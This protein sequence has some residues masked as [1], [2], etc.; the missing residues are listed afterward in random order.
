MAKEDL[1]LLTGRDV[2]LQSLEQRK[3]YGAMLEG[4]PTREKNQHL[5]E[6]LREQARRLLPQVE[7]Y[8]VPPRETPIPWRRAEKYP[9][10]DPAR[11]PSVACIAHFRSSSPARTPQLDYSELVVVWLQEEFAFPID[12]LVLEHLLALDWERL[13]GEW[14]Y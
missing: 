4:L 13:A 10:G 5:L 2:Q 9:F 7:P 8:L 6:S 3:V 14:E 11:L 12:P 1:K